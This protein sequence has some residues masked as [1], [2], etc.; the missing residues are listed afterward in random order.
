MAAALIILLPSFAYADIAPNLLS[1]EAYYDFD[2]SAKGGR[3]LPLH[4]N[5]N[6]NTGVDYEG[7]LCIFTK[8]A[9]QEILEYSESTTIYA[10]SDNEKLYYIPLA[11]NAS[12]IH[13]EVKD[14]HGTEL[15]RKTVGLN[16]EKNTAELFVGILS[17]A[18]EFLEY[19]DNVSINYGL[20]RSRL[21]YLDN[22]TF[23]A[24]AM[25]LD[26]MDVILISNYTIRDLSEIQ[27]RAMMDWVK[28][29]GVLILGTGERVDDTLGR[30]APELL[31][32]MYEEPYLAD[33]DIMGD[34]ETEEIYC[35]D[36]PLHGGN[37]VLSGDKFALLSS[38][39]KEKGAIV[40]S[41]YD[42]VDT[43]DFALEHQSYAGEVLALSLGER[44]ME[45]LANEMYGKSGGEYESVA[46][47]VQTGDANRIPPI[48]VYTL[49]IMAYI[50]LA[51]PGLYLFLKHRDASGY[52]R[53]G[54]VILSVFF[55]ALIFI[56]GA[57]TRFEDTFYN[58]VSIIDTDE[59][60]MNETSYL[61][62]RNPYNKSYSVSLGDDYLIFPISENKGSLNIQENWDVPFE[63]N[64]IV[65]KIHG[66]NSVSV[67]DVGAFTPRIFKLT[68][69]SENKTGECFYGAINLF[70]DTVSGSITNG[71]N[72][73]V[74]KTCVMLYG[75]MI[76]LGDMK[77]GE[78]RELDGLEVINIPIS[79]SDKVAAVISGENRYTDNDELRADYLKTVEEGNILSFYRDNYLMGYSADAKVIAFSSDADNSIIK[80]QDI[81]GYGMKLLVSSVSVD[82]RNEEE[83]A[84]TSALIKSPVCVS[85]DYADHDNTMG[86]MEPAV[87]EYQ[88][89]RDIEVERLVFE[90]ADPETFD[91]LFSGSFAFYNIQTGV[92]DNQDMS[93]KG[94]NMAELGQYI[95]D[96]NTITVRYTYNAAAPLDRVALPTVSVAG[97]E[98]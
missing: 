70:E 81:Q 26:Q 48:M 49:S 17:D 72:R 80:K 87:L 52:Y 47:L 62:L 33:V 96:D 44:R 68:R 4:I 24:D 45:A 38:V 8:A 6:N 13:I 39:N 93:I 85:G 74:K 84:Y 16:I 28:A 29:G 76:M 5:I 7:E 78:T 25:G 55:T 41:A 20:L 98:F 31:D 54:V 14:E 53:I 27:T 43:Y 97:Y 51:G 12:S 30:F 56:M 65:A 71:Y 23:P 83:M 57:R 66:E 36:A 11:L 82:N 59:D 21:F 86:T 40:V 61:D 63:A 89:G 18:P 42:F 60:K 69:T 2:N 50:L 91:D 3:Y 73:D 95:T 10:G 79:D 34:G 22:K 77:A 92:Y 15:I 37:V 58:Y 90:W 75:R 1:M 94:F 9:D 32:D 64:T 46:G 35:V 19:F 67:E 88:L